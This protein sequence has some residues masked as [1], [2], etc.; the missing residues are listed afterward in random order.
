MKNILYIIL[1]STFSLLSCKAQQV[2]NR[3][4]FNQG[5]NEGKYFKDL[6]NNFAPFIGTWEW[7]N[8]SQI[9]RIT[10]WK[11]EMDEYKNGNKPSFYMD[12]IKG[13][14]EMVETGQLPE[15]IIYTSNKKVGNGDIYYLPAISAS[16]GDGISC[17]SSL[18]DN[19][20]TSNY[21]GVA[22]DFSLDTIPNTNPVQATFNV[23][24]RDGE[25]FNIPTNITLTKVN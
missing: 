17:G 4:T 24:S 18:L 22:C 2:V 1:F 7:Q 3:T 16:S 20:I 23:K 13:H 15:T 21:Y 11:V 25:S 5:N 14:F 9:F 10:L 8:G 12:V 19:S 6:D